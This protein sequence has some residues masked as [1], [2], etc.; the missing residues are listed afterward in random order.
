MAPSIIG[1]FLI[2]AIPAN[3]DFIVAGSCFDCSVFKE[4]FERQLL[5]KYVRLAK[6][7]GI[8]FVLVH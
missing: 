4:I 6:A 7:L 8:Y 2:K 1:L 5:L 3:N